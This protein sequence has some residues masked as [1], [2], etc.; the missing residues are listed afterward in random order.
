LFALTLVACASQAEGSIALVTGPEEGVLTRAPE[1]RTLVVESVAEDRTTAE[2]A[3][4]SLPAD[5]IDLGDLA[6]DGVAAFRVRGE[7]S[8][9]AVRVRGESLPLRYGALAGQTLPLYVQRTGESARFPSSFSGAFPTRTLALVAN[10]YIM[11]SEGSRGLFYDLASLAPTPERTLSLAA[12]SV[13][14]QGSRLLL[15]S[16]AAQAKVLDVSTGEETSVDPPAGGTFADVAGGLTVIGGAEAYVVG[17]TQND[18]ETS[19]VLRVTAEL[20]LS[21]VELAHPRRGAGAAFA[22]GRGLVVVGGSATAPGLEVLAQ[23]ATRGAALA[24][25]PLADTTLALAVPAPS[26]AIVVGGAVALRAADLSC[27]AGCTFTNVAGA[28]GPLRDADAVPVEGRVLAGGTDT[29]GTA[30]VFFV[31]DAGA[32]EIPLKAPRSAVRFVPLPTG[33]VA[34]VGGGSGVLE[35]FRP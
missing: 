29:A 3:R 17:A 20:G 18:R 4:V 30:R 22:E 26:R 24:F 27:G 8:G 14:A 32:R 23:G 2:I 13:V 31:E 16:E 21:F 9:G 19:R 11:G 33:N 10:R 25:P 34:I 5:T 12:R 28:A 7:D 1:V 15:V 35:S 6:K